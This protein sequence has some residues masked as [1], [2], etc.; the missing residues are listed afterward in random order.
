MEHLIA[1]SG[2][3]FIT[4][5]VEFNPTEPFQYQN[6]H[7]LKFAFCEQKDFLTGE[8]LF[9]LLCY[10][11]DESVY[12][13]LSEL[14]E[15]SALE[16]TSTG[17]EVLDEMG[18]QR[19]LPD[20]STALFGTFKDGDEEVFGIN[21]LG[22]LRLP[23]P[24]GGY[25]K[26]PAWEILL[27]K[28]LPMP[29]LEMAGTDGVMDSPLGWC[30]V[31]IDDLG[32]GI[33]KGARR[34]RLTWAF[35]TA[36]AD[37]PL[38]VMR[39]YFYPN[40]TAPKTYRLCPQTD[41]MLSFL[42][43]EEGQNAFAEYILSLCGVKTDG[44]QESTAF[45][46]LGW[47]VYLTA[48][49][50]EVGAAPEVQLYKGDAREI[51]VDLVLDIGNSRTCGVL[52][53]EGDFTRAQMLELR[54]LTEPHKFYGNPFD[55][56][57]VFRK[58]DFGGALRLDEDFFVWKSFVR[59]G[60]EARRLV[61]RSRE[62]ADTSEL[63]TNYSSPKRYLWDEATFE[64]KWQ[65]LVSVNDP[66]NVNIDNNIYIKGLSEQFDAQGHFLPDG[67]GLDLTFH[68]S[69][70]SLMTF[71]M[72]EV[73]Q[74]AVAQINGQRFRDTHGNVDCRRRLRH[75]IITSPT[76]MPLSEQATLRQAAVDAWQAIMNLNP[77]LSPA[78]VFPSPESLKETS[79]F[80]VKKR[81]WSY[82][83]ASCCQLVYLYAEL[84]QRY[85][86][87]VARF[88]EM[89]GHVRD[90]LKA[91]GYDKKALTIGSV[92]IG[93]GTTD[94]MICAYEYEG[95]TGTRI[96]PVPK[97]WDSFYLAG[98]DILRRLIQTFVIE[99]D[100]HATP[101]LG[102]IQSSL[103]QRLLVA[104]DD[105]LR[106]LPCLEG[107]SLAAG[108]Y[109]GKMEDILH[110]GSTAERE[111]AIKVFASNLVHDFFGV[112]SN[113]MTA[114]D[115]RNRR[116]FN[117][118]ISVPIAQLLLDL[119][120]RHRPSR[121][122]TYD[123][124]FGEMPPSTYLLEAF[125]RHFGFKLQELEW[126]YDPDRVAS[127]IR[128]VLEPLMRQLAVVL[129][130]YHCDILVLA[131]RPTSLDTITELFVKYYPLSPDRLIRLGDYH[132]GTWYPFSDGQGYFFD[133]KSVVAVGGM[134][135]HTASH[136]GFNGLV[137]DFSRM[138]TEMRPTAHYLGLFDPATQQVKETL[139]SP[140]KSTVILNLYTFP[141]FIGCKQIEGRTYQARPL[142]G[143]YNDSGRSTLRLC[144]SRN[145]HED[146]ERIELEE[147]SDATGNNLPKTAV[148]LV[149][150]SLADD[151]KYWLDKGEFELSIK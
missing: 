90:E 46:V 72:V 148:R 142:Y 70:S 37:N 77:A 17:Q 20:L 127:D 138:T 5:E 38:S 36:T 53:E 132:V 121:I 116:D 106:A 103:E 83:E 120:R 67:A 52:F 15:K 87:E 143:I 12:V 117:T 107:M 71:V 62:E 76:A 99:G 68:Y 49:L 137:I 3:Q 133:Q 144:L 86:G 45:H 150:Q 108:V 130:A 136:T 85:N 29:M 59:V 129:Y 40:E 73:L 139:L 79:D 39:P 75:I 6:G 111:N 93:A 102:C 56:R 134:V 98:D 69:R 101:T 64:G 97:F 131:G 147:V 57:I 35:D 125:E 128:A 66:A 55:M 9:D 60:E 34:Y 44:T 109:R 149:P 80:G 19:M 110:A 33:H 7:L 1:D 50:R 113:L 11:P 13:T 100:H 58:A 47:Y 114:R 81:Q 141:A 89:K 48:F 112:D 140:E 88:F 30:R 31:K 146:R 16:L 123:E 118:Q 21:A 28:W 18:L 94:I 27:G 14:R 151:G 115:R 119:L 10:K 105:E 74:Q 84:A 95:D 82:D 24:A 22:H 63:C 4:R 2:L 32:E 61:Y 91:E 126:R 42:S 25:E 145:Y 51:D 78:Q 96:V 54:D 135:G 124:I 92:D 43:L 26:I 122:Y 41:H 23:D 65:T 104:T 8:T